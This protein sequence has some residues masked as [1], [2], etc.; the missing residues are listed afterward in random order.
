M[1]G[2]EKK[3]SGTEKNEWERKKMV[4]NRKKRAGPKKPGLN[5]IPS[6][7]SILSETN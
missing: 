3:W 4:R 1:N 2:N 6:F 7:Q 5:S